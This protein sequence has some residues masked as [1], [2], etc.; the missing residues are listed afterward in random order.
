MSADVGGENG[1]HEKNIEEAAAR[2]AGRETDA[3]VRFASRRAR[4]H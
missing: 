2:E 3:F 4:C 1:A